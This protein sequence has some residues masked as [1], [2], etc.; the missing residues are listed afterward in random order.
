MKTNSL[1]CRACGVTDLGNGCCSHASG[2]ERR[3]LLQAPGIHDVG[4]FRWAGLY[5]VGDE[6]DSAIAGTGSP[7]STIATFPLSKGLSGDA[8]RTRAPV[9][10]GDVATDT[11]HMTAFPSAKSEIIVPVLVRETV[12]GTIDVESENVDAF[13]NPD[14]RV[15]QDCARAARQLWALNETDPHTD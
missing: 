12:L 4:S 9:V 11:A 10:V 6:Q 1:D 3:H 7:A 8:V 15:L 5:D 14:V 13:S 2:V